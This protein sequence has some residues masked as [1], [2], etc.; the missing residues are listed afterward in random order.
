MKDIMERLPPLS[1]SLRE[2]EINHQVTSTTPA[3]KQSPIRMKAIR[4][5]LPL[6]RTSLRV[7]AQ[8]S[9]RLHPPPRRRSNHP[10]KNINDDSFAQK[11][12]HRHAAIVKNQSDSLTPK[13]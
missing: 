3:T 10:N 9:P 11:K 5:R 12:P 7:A 1:T 13:K 2:A 6:L 8:K 4:K